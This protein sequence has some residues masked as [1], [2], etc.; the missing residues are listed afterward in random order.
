MLM[1]FYCYLQTTVCTSARATQLFFAQITDIMSS[2][3][4]A[5]LCG[6]GMGRTMNQAAAVQRWWVPYCEP[7]CSCAAGT[8]KLNVRGRVCEGGIDATLGL[9]GLKSPLYSPPLQ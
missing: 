4:Y 9:K 5:E 6:A 7:A 1:M 2:H 8:M 3:L